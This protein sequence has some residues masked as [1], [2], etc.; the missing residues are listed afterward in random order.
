MGVNSGLGLGR[1]G[2]YRRLG[3]RAM[4]INRGLE[5]RACR[6]SQ[7]SRVEGYGG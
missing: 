3:F 7:A 2:V 5:F 1:V 4:G 6:G